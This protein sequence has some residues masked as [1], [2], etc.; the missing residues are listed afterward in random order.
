[1]E[2]RLRDVSVVRGG[3][4]VLDVPDL[5]FPSGAITAV[6]GPNGSGKTT[7]LRCIAG[8]ERPVRGRVE[9]GAGTEQRERHRIAYAFQSAVFVRG[10]VRE[11]LALGLALRNVPHA[12]RR[13][14]IEAAAEECGIVPL[15]ERSARELSGGESQRVNVARALALGAPLTLLDEPLAGVDRATRAQLLDDLPG[16][17]ERFARTA[18]V[19]THDRE[20]AFRL[21]EHLVV[22]AEGKVLAA[23]AKRALFLAP[24][25][26][27]TAAL[28]GYTVIELEDRVVAVPAGALA[29]AADGERSESAFAGT[30]RRVVD[31]GDGLHLLADVGRS[32]VDVPLGIS[33]AV[34]APGMAVWIVPRGA[35]PIIFSARRVEPEQR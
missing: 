3:R 2:V 5:A 29:L 21:A 22:L 19:V 6:F 16:M 23:G 7:L 15:L 27:A 11:N 25:S 32:R 20:E 26:S 33:D 4:A 9:Y 17:L 34:P 13:P 12:E 8:L 28:L 35:R 14:R 31:M 30:A 24:P 1:M 18:I 10:T